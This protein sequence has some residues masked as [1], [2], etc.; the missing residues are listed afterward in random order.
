[1]IENINLDAVGILMFLKGVKVIEG[2][3]LHS[4]GWNPRKVPF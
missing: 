1:M 4:K 2:I 3:D